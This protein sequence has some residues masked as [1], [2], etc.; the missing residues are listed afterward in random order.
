MKASI[1][2]LLGAPL[3]SQNLARTGAVTLSEHFDVL[4]IDCTSWVYPNST[5]QVDNAEWESLITINSLD[6]FRDFLTLTRIDFALDFIGDLPIRNQIARTLNDFNSYL[7]L[8][9]LGQVPRKIKLTLRI[10]EIKKKT[11]NLFPAKKIKGTTLPNTNY[12]KPGL[13]LPNVGFIDRLKKIVIDPITLRRSNPYIILQTGNRS[14]SWISILA[15]RVIRIASNDY[16]T[17]TS[18]QLESKKIISSDSNFVL[19]IDDCLVEA[20]DWQI[21]GVLSPIDKEKYFTA[22]NSFFDKIEDQLKMQVKIAG[23]PNTNGNI[24]YDTNFSPRK[25]FYSQTSKLTQEASM[26]LLHAST[27]ASFAVLAEKPLVTLTSDDIAQT[28]IGRQVQVVS[29]ALGTKIVNLDYLDDEIEIPKINKR[30]YRNYR[31]HLLKGDEVQELGQLRNF[32][33]AVPHLLKRN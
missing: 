10:Q 27:A 24:A 3:T 23:H 32:I 16:H 5:A 9:K 29:H 11:T 25:V 12:V 4:I 21:L 26:V 33:D 22:L 30:R 15:R 7:V 8:Q 31:N 1:A 2:I 18:T 19:F 6:G 20:L 13:S 14:S 28:L 17:F